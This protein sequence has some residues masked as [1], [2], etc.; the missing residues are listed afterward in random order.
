MGL[1]VRDLDLT[2]T[3]FTDT[4]GFKKVGERPE[5]PAMFVSDGHIMITLWQVSEPEKAR[6]FD[7]HE[8]VGLHHLAL[9]VG[10]TEDLEAVHSLLQDAAGVEIEAPPQPLGS[11]P[12]VHMMCREPGGI[13][14]E[15]ITRETHR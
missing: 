12:G 3:F 6:Q 14:I 15:F 11:A 1:A 5:Y 4:L 7:R 10:T 9:R 13:R 2:A 8:N